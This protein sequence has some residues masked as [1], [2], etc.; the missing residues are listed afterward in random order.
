MMMAK[1]MHEEN[2]HIELPAKSES[3]GRTKEFFNINKTK[4]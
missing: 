1:F 4:T 3:Q 2:D